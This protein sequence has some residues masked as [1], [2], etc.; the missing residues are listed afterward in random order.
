LRPSLRFAVSLVRLDTAF[1]KRWEFVTASK[2]SEKTKTEISIIASEFSEKINRERRK[3]KIIDVAPFITLLVMLVIMSCFVQGF[4][5]K[6][7][8]LGL[9]NQ[10]SAP[11]VLA[12]GLTFVLLL[13]S[14]DLSVEGVLGMIGSLVALLVLNT[15]NANNHGLWAV[16]AVLVIGLL[17]GLVNGIIHVKLRIPSFMV[18]FGMNSIA[19]G[20]AVLSYGGAPPGILDPT[21]EKIVQ[22]TAL[23]IPYLTL[24]ALL[25]F[26]VGLVI[27]K[28]TAFGK[29]VYAIGEN[30][31]VLWSLGINVERVKI[32]VFGFCALCTSVAGVFGAMRLNRGDATM[33]SGMLFT[34]I[35][36]VVVGGTS[37]SGGKG[38]LIQSLVGVLIVAL[39]RNA[40]VLLGVN[41]YIQAAIQGL[42]IIL[43]VSLT[44]ARGRKLII[45]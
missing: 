19:M 34:A 22:G 16:A 14:I 29:Y 15:K 12:T 24:A 23:G 28:F 21:F 36:A 7:N 10:I 44:V 9:M 45:K 1:K 3:S 2:N 4:F 40:M 37:L 18:T 41:A 5:S 32:L 17:V 31:S 38:G 8:F 35:T 39:I 11:L 13:G 30:E 25:I 43:V 27:Q 26:L 20:F 6:A 33:G 42:I